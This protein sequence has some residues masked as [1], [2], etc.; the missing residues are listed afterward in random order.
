M[1]RIQG[2]VELCIKL[3]TQELDVCEFKVFECVGRTSN[4]E[5]F[6]ELGTGVQ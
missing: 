2:R 1:S 5:N 4:C 3:K 6:K